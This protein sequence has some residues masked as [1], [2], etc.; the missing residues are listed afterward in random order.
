M[1]TQ[2]RPVVTCPDCG[3][4]LVT[5]VVSRDGGW[6]TCWRCDSCMEFYDMLFMKRIEFK[7]VRIF[8]PEGA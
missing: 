1:D 7:M 8:C 3:R 2:E 6:E 4:N 5:R